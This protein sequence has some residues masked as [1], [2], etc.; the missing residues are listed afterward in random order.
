MK[1]LKIDR[2]YIIFTVLL[3]ALAFMVIFTLRISFSAVSVASEIDEELLQTQTPRIN[4]DKIE[5]ALGVL[6]RKERMPLDLG[7]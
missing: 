4:K 3:M 5:Q 1:N 6:G 2:F 7:L